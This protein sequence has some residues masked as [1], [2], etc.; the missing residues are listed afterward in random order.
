M[1]N[2]NPYFQQQ[3]NASRRTAILVVS[4]SSLFCIL[5]IAFL[6]AISNDTNTTGEKVKSDDIIDLL[7][8]PS[9]DLES[10]A[11]DS[12]DLGIELPQGGWIQ[13]TDSNGKLI[14]QYRCQSLDPNPPLRSDGWIEMDKPEVELYFGNKKIVITGNSAA[15]NAPKRIL[16]SGSIDGNVRV[17]VFEI[18][19]TGITDKPL[20]ELQTTIAKF[21]NLIGEINCPGEVRITSDT[22]VLE[23]RKLSVR[24]N[25]LEERI[26]LVQLEELDYI[27]LSPNNKT[28]PSSVATNTA[29]VAAA[30]TDPFSSSQSVATAPKE[31]YIATFDKNVTIQQ[32]LTKISKLAHGDKLTIAFSNESKDTTA[33]TYYER[34]DTTMHIPQIALTIPATIVA[35]TLANNQ[36]ATDDSVKVTCEGGLTLIPLYDETR[37]PSSKQD[38]RVEL[39]AFKD[40]P[41]TILDSDNLLSAKGTLLRFELPGNK[42]DLYGS[43][44]EL[45]KDSIL[46]SAGH[47]WVAQNDGAGGAHGPGT[48]TSKANENRQTTLQWSDG[49]DFS[50]AKSDNNKDG[51]LQSVVCNGD[52]ILSDQGNDILCEQLEVH[53]EPDLQGASAPKNALASGNVKAKSDSQTLWAN[54]VEVTFI[55]TDKTLADDG[56]MFGGSHAD[57]MKAI[58]DVQILLNDGG[59]AFC[60]T[61]DGH[62]TQDS[63]SLSGNVVI[64]YQRMLMNRGDKASLTLDRTTGKGRWE[65]AGQAMFLNE[66]LDVSPDRRI[67]RPTLR[68]VDD[69]KSI[70]MRTNW[71]DSMHLDQTYNDG[72]GAIDLRGDVRVLSQ[73][74]AQE[75]SQMTGN[76][77][78]L[79]FSQT[80]DIRELQ[81]VI[82]KDNSQIEHR[83]WDI[84]L[85]ENPP[86]VYYIGGNHLEF[87]AK[88]QEALAVGNGELV[89]RDPRRASVEVHQSALA[90]RGTTRFT[91]DNKLKTTK[92][93]GNTYR[94]EMSGNV[95]MVHKGLDGA[96]GMLTSDKIQ[97]I[98]IDPDIPTNL[99]SSGAE[100]TMRGLDL[101]QIYANGRVY[102]ATQTRRVDCDDFEYNLKT[103]FA[104]LTA[105]EDNTIAI[106][107][108]GT[109]YPVRATSI[110]WNMDPAVDTISIR[111][112][113]GTNN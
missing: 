26:E 35:A 112:L 93:E 22:H 87:E 91:W 44:A 17:L 77:L 80:D 79:E 39:F 2:K 100:L 70:S 83:T 46:T 16:E 47:L 94:L 92:L 29:P 21:D 71:E 106:V 14:Q 52:V 36:I 67:E 53:F 56:S 55:D 34:P 58:G 66:P 41:A 13:Q 32:G 60:D 98:A 78:R 74:S 11:I 84:L 104:K 7:S 75:R 68:S 42:I 113:Q 18:N 102:V 59:R 65:G 19:D 99:D 81:K 51:A 5:L 30:E 69:S 28:T 50:F 6:F 61:L 20:M 111:G 63:A 86:V 15:A 76:D 85:P 103:G 25:D 96:I 88:T 108:E 43:P 4:I 82:A 48:M 64:A 62:I 12:T 109:S 49:V 9:N 110:I 101:Q 97:A 3:K 45:Y 24:F 8:M 57:A 31:F 107:T 27:L 90:G 33:K 105:K 10:V 23:G 54:T 40:E 1:S 38:T 72:A 73:R 95:E 89:L 37:L